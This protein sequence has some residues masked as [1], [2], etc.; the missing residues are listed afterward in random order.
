[1]EFG[2]SSSAP[3][4]P[5]RDLDSAKRPQV[6]FPG[7]K[8]LFTVGDP[9]ALAAYGLAT[10]QPQRFFKTYLAD[11]VLDEISLTSEPETAQAPE[12]A[13]HE[14]PRGSG[15]PRFAPRPYYYAASRSGVV[16]SWIASA[17]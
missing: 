9:L 16:P 10:V 2:G 15:E 7:E 13:K 6:P 14:L 12:T 1:M 17:H 3:P 4:V 11:R 5:S 8:L